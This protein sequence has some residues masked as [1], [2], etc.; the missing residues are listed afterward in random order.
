ML[1]P[2]LFHIAFHPNTHSAQNNR[3]KDS[4]VTSAGV[5]CP[6]WL[7]VRN[8]VSTVKLVVL[9]LN[10]KPP[11]NKTTENNTAKRHDAWW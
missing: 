1:F 8:V 7:C 5:A 2:A 11:I 4:K 3:N 10:D 6:C 9:V